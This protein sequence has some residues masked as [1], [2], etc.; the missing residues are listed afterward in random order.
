MKDEILKIL[1]TKG[2]KEDKIASP[3]PT[4]LRRM[5]RRKE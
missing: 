1:E 2:W 4:L 5:V 3:D